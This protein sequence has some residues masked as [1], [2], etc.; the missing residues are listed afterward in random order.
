MPDTSAIHIQTC[1]CGLEVKYKD[2]HIGRTLPCSNCGLDITLRKPYT[3]PQSVQRVVVHPEP[4]EQDDA[5][6]ALEDPPIDLPGL[7]LAPP[8]LVTQA[9]PDFETDAS[10]S[11][12]QRRARTQANRRSNGFWK[13]AGRAITYLRSLDAWV[14]TIVLIIMLTLANGFAF[15]PILGLLGKI[16]GNG[17]A[18]TFYFN[19]I[20]HS[21]GGDDE[22]P[23]FEWE[24]W[25]ESGLKPIFTFLFIT[26][27][28][29]APGFAL[30][31]TM[32]EIRSSQAS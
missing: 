31:T 14:K 13:D 16:I 20:V 27:V 15:V 17:I 4:L 30:T 24:G 25:W 8:V 12:E 29:F 3:K 21:S 9:E 22:L 2:K 7:D 6:F 10:E 5:P 26:L 28:I 32:P 23:D 1:P 19:T 18:I 11:S